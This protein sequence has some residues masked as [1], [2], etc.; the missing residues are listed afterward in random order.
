[1]K[2]I[3]KRYADKKMLWGTEV[4]CRTSIELISIQMCYCEGTLKDLNT[5]K[6]KLL[7]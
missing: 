4:R 1:M 5:Q 6:R 7:L 3:A 2:T